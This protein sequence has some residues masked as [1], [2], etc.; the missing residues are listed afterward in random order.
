[1]GQVGVVVGGVPGYGGA[2]S[3]RIP[4]YGG[5]GKHGSGR[6]SPAVVGQTDVVVGGVPCCDD[7]SVGLVHI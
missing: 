7:G 1:M 3:G 2:G 6:R 5:V 4:S